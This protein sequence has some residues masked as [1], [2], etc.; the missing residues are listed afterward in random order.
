MARNSLA[1]RRGHAPALVEQERAPVRLLEF[2][3]ATHHGTGKSPSLMAE[4]LRFEEI[5]WNRG[6]VHRHEA[7]LAPAAVPMQI[8]RQHLLAGATL[9]GDQHAGVRGRDLA[10]DGQKLLHPQVLGHQLAGAVDKLCSDG[11]DERRLGRQRQEALGPSSV[12]HCGAR[13]G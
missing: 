6:A 8:A 11:F 10:R 5:F 1:C 2:A 4:Q 13:L 12:D 9:A 7:L 3:D